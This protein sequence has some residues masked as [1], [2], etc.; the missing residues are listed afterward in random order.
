MPASR[1][2]LKQQECGQES[3]QDGESSEGMQVCLVVVQ[4]P[5][6]VRTSGLLAVVLLQEADQPHVPASEGGEQ[7]GGRAVGS[8]RRSYSA[9]GSL[10][11]IWLARPG[12][13]FGK[14]GVVGENTRVN[15]A[16]KL[17]D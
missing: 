5:D 7:S 3:R 10:G 6:A 8:G 14:R 17:P 1:T 15:E 12:A 9:K 11:A 4:G 16:M 13:F 2:G